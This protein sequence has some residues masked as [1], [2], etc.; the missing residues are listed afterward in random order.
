MGT[1]HVA[2]ARAVVCDRVLVVSVFTSELVK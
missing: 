1:I 2:D